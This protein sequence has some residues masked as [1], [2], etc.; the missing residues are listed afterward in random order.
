[1]RGYLRKLVLTIFLLLVYPAFANDI[2]DV[3]EDKIDINEYLAEYNDLKPVQQ[4][5]K[6][7]LDCEM[8]AELFTKGIFYCVYDEPKVLDVVGNMATYSIH[9][10]LVEMEYVKEIA[11]KLRTVK[12]SIPSLAN[13]HLCPPDDCENLLPKNQYM[14]KDDRNF[15]RIALLDREIATT[16][17]RNNYIQISVTFNGKE[18]ASKNFVNSYEELIISVPKECEIKNITAKLCCIYGDRNEPYEQKQAS[19]FWEAL[20][21]SWPTILPKNV[22]TITGSIDIESNEIYERRMHYKEE[23]A[24]KKEWFNFKYEDVCKKFVSEFS[25]DNEDL[26]NISLYINKKGE[27][28]F[29]VPISF[30]TKHYVGGNFVVE[31]DEGILGT[32]STKVNG[33]TILWEDSISYD[34]IVKAYE[35]DAKFD[36]KSKNM[37]SF[38]FDFKHHKYNVQIKSIVNDPD[39]IRFYIQDKR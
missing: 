7:R 29:K 33:K 22:H 4:F 8:V 35:A 24:N 32:V 5:E 9:F 36:E 30:L 12:E 17:E 23:E 39:G 34:E 19:N 26:K 20:F 28:V 10:K 38:I 11:W 27:H 3:Y 15:V 13:C 21:T 1:M 16:I 18:Y 37:I 25:E 14:E 6:F 2:F 31:Y